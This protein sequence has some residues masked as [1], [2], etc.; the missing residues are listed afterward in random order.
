MAR[1]IELFTPL[2]FRWVPERSAVWPPNRSVPQLG[3]CDGMPDIRWPFEASR[4]SSFTPEMRREEWKK[5][6]YPRKWQKNPQYGFGSESMFMGFHIWRPQK[7][8]VDFVHFSSVHNIYKCC[9]FT[10]F[11]NILCGHNIWTLPLSTLCRALLPPRDSLVS[12]VEQE[13]KTVGNNRC[14]IADHR[15]SR[16]NTV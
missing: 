7:E 15:P 9:L 2:V 3:V 13:C 16:A 8:S 1:N 12:V 10:N 4:R 14:I 5:R 6:E 11:G